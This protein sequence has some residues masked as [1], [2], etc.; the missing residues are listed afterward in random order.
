MPMTKMKDIESK[1]DKDLSDFVAEKREAVRNFR[2]TH[3]SSRTRNV[4]Q[5]RADKKDIARALTEQ[6]K[7]TKEAQD[8]A[9]NK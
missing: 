3:A 2:F 9:N 7:R 8:K 5:I 1:S 4:R 6:T